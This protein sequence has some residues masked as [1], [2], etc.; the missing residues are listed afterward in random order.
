MNTTL[1]RFHTKD[2]IRLDGL[3]FEPESTTE[4]IV[5]HVHGTADYFYRQRFC[6]DIAKELTSKG[7]A[8]LTFDNRGAHEEYEFITENDKNER[9]GT[10]VIGARNE[11]FED[12]IFDIE[13]AI[14]FVKSR[15]YKEIVLQGH[16]YGCNKIVL[17]AIEKQFKGRLVLLAPCDMFELAKDPARNPQGALCKRRSD[18]KFDIFRYK[19]ESVLPAISKLKNQILVEIGTDDDAIYQTDKQQCI[20]YL[21]KAF[22]GSELTC[23]LLK[24]VGHC[25]QGKYQELATN[26]ANWLGEK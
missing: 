12:C 25:Y 26:I 19:S 7:Y 15:G 16:R 14:N 20:D 8:F 22:K 9:Q 5:I 6:D 1:V 24:D 17:Y 11:I 18:E 2:K 4:K 13:S 21:K 3:L 23:H 10:V